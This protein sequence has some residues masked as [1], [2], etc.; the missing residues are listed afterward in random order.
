MI[1]TKSL[2][3]LIVSFVRFID[4]GVCYLHRRHCVIDLHVCLLNI[5]GILE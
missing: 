2:R 3:I 5:L 1:N 4:F